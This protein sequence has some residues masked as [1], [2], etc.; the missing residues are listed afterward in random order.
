MLLIPLSALR[1]GRSRFC[2]SLKC[3]R[4]FHFHQREI[5]K[6]PL[7]PVPGWLAEDLRVWGAQTCGHLLTHPLS[8][9]Q[10]EWFPTL[11]HV[12][13]SVLCQPHCHTTAALLCPPLRPLLPP[14]FHP[15]SATW[16]PWSESGS[17]VS[18]SL[19][20]H[21]LYSPWNS[22]GQNTGVGSLSL[23]QAI[24]PTQGSNPGLPHCRRILYQ[25]SH[26]GRHLRPTDV[27]YSGLKSQHLAQYLVY[28]RYSINGCW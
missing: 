24:F 5:K 13:V 28:C 7:C 10:S 23:L 15:L 4:K 14:P 11:A 21:G 22:P 9:P 16:G 20:P 25:L 12:R 19:Q 1:Y 8:A 18:N 2:F 6:G 27:S 26:K 3:W 17:V